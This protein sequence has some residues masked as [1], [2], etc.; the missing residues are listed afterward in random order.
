[1]GMKFEREFEVEADRGTVWE[2]LMDFENSSRCF[3]GVDTFVV[4]PDGT[5][6]GTVGI[7]I[8]PLKAEFEGEARFVEQEPPE[9]LRAEARAYDP[10][11]RSDVS[12]DV[13]GWLE[14]HGADRT[15]IRY[16][17]DIGLIDAPMAQMAYPLI[18]S[19]TEALNDEFVRR[20]QAHFATHGDPQ[21]VASR[22]RW[23]ILLEILVRI[24]GRPLGRSAG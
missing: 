12:V 17:M 24:F 6:A 20:L 18:K 22:S 21:A 19:T 9:R 2:F 16:L 11:S 8:G 10:I 3:P 4:Q 23:R 14:E 7:D 1:M 15:G 5:F 13:Q